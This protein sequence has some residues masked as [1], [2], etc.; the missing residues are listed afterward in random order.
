MTI[1]CSIPVVLPANG[2]TLAA[3]G[4]IALVA[5]RTLADGSVRCHVAHGVGAAAARILAA[6][7]YACLGAGTLAVGS[8]AKRCGN[9]TLSTQTWG[10]EI[11]ELGYLAGFCLGYKQ[12]RGE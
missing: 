1:S 10:C 2:L 3:D 9:D 12:N 7:V 6:A 4:R 5:G 8:T 11:M